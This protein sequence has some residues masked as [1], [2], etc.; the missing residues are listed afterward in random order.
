MPFGSCFAVQDEVR[1]TFGEDTF[2]HIDSIISGSNDRLSCTPES[3]MMKICTMLDL[4]SISHLSQ[5]NRHLRKIC[6]SDQL[7]NALYTQH[8]GHPSQE[9]CAVASDIGW[10]AVFYSN[11]LQLQ[12]E[13]SRRRKGR[14]GEMDS[15]GAAGE[16]SKSSN[17]F[18]TDK[19]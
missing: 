11:K 2:L 19:S 14:Q 10:K 17:T 1:R 3:I 4:Q 16:T 9:I 12:K 7:W 6:T 15:T 5:V 18:L 13:L 8:Q